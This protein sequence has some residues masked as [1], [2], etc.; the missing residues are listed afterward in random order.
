MYTSMI[1]RVGISVVACFGF[2][3][4]ALILF[5]AICPWMDHTIVPNFSSRSIDAITLGTV[6]LC[7]IFVTIQFVRGKRWAWVLAFT[8]ALILFGLALYLLIAFLH[9]RDEFAISE[10]GFGLVLSVGLMLPT[11][12]SI[13]LL[14]VPP[15]RNRFWRRQPMA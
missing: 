5:Y 11:S 15:V 14:N 13:L 8:A 2:A 4:A 10:G 9:P 12:I 1:G 3:L 6:G 7:C